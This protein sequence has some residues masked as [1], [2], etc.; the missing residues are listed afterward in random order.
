MPTETVRVALRPPYT[1]ARSAC[2]LALACACALASGP[3]TGGGTAATGGTVVGATVPSATYVDLDECPADVVQMGVV[4]PTANGFTDD[5][6][7]EFGSSNDSSSLRLFQ[8]D[9]QDDGMYRL[10]H[11]DPDVS[12]DDDGFYSTS[13]TA[14]AD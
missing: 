5:C 7:V 1:R 11:G 8:T 2:L 10:A 14:G 3:L 9:E 4:L 12:F 6:T 13:W